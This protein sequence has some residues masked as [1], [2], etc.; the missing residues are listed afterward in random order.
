MRLSQKL[1]REHRY[2]VVSPGNKVLDTSESTHHLTWFWPRE[3]NE[4]LQQSGFTIDQTIGNFD[5]DHPCDDNSQI[6][7]IIASRSSEE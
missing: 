2:E 3:I 6:I 5:F 7:T 4:M 1:I